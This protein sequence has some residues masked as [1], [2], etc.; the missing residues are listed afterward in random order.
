MFVKGVPA[1]SVARTRKL[2]YNTFLSLNII[3]LLLE[4][5]DQKSHTCSSWDKPNPQMCFV[6]PGCFWPT[7]WVFVLF[8]LKTKLASHL[9]SQLLKIKEFHIKIQIF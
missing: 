3:V 8:C 4:F 2:A 7:L 9:R 6:W 5:L 1:S